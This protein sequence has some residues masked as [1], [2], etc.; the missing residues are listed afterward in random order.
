MSGYQP[1]GPAES[2]SNSR[3]RVPIYAAAAAFG[4]CALYSTQSLVREGDLTSVPMLP[5]ANLQT[6][7]I[8]TAP[9]ADPVEAI[10]AN[11]TIS[12]KIGQMIQV[13]LNTV[14]HGR[15]AHTALNK[16]MVRHYAK[17]GIGSYFNTAFD[18]SNANLEWNVKEWKHI[19]DEINRIYAEEHAVPMIY[20]IDMTHGAN[21]IRG[22]AMFP[23]PLAGASSF[24]L[25]L[26]YRMGEI[27]A[28]D[29]LAAGLQ[30]LFSPILGIAMHPK[31]ARNYETFGEDPYLVSRMGTSVIRGMQA[32]NRTAACMKHFIAYSNPINGNDRTDS[33]VPDFELANYYSPPF[34]A[35]VKEGNV[36][37]AMETYV[38]VNGEPVVASHKLLTD[39]LRHDM[40]FEGLLV[41]DDDEFH[42]L[43]SEHHAANNDK[44]AIY[45][46]FNHTSMDMNM[47]S[48]KPYKAHR[49]TEQLVAK[50]LLTEARLDE[51]VRRIL[52]LKYDLGVL[53]KN[54]TAY[55][56]PTAVGS[57]ED[58]RD[59][60]AMADEAIILLKNEPVDHSK[61]ALPIEDPNASVF[62]TG[63]LA[64]SKA[65]L[66]GGWSTVWQGTYKDSE[67]ANSITIR[68]GLSKSFSKLQFATGV[69]VEGK[70]VENR[71]EVLAKAAK[72]AYTIVVIG[73]HS[74]AE[75]TGDSDNLELPQGQLEYVRQLT[76]LN[77]T[78]VILVVVEG[79]PRL[80]NGV[81]RDAAAV[82]LSFLPCE[83]GGQAFA[84]IITGHVNPSAKLPITYPKD[85]G[86]V[87]L[88]Y[89]HRVNTECRDEFVD[90]DM[91]WTFGSGLSYTT[92][93]YGHVTLSQH[94]VP[95]TGSITVSVPVKNTGTRAGKESV[96]L[97]VS[98]K[99]RHNYVPETKLLK[100]FHKVSLKPNETTIVNFTLSTSDWS[101][102]E[103][104]IGKG[105]KTIS[106]PGAFHIQIKHDTDCN[107]N[108]HL[109]K[110]FHVEA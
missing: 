89:F 95:S 86:N 27:E 81:T 3:S 55:V 62:L 90:C 53:D 35:A 58:Q 52:R 67:I 105:F 30:W 45:Q 84:D 63:P 26:A 91:E 38:S 106:E 34:I 49:L 14:L 4:L 15:N 77:T 96:L 102:H 43:I 78:K 71:T 6:V 22:A 109:C 107:E 42:R 100:K 5:V 44:D 59:A 9:K 97:F 70:E 98:Q 54:Q 79:R 21:Y 85:S 88:P 29:S 56:P 40:G 69:D 74:Y 11:L 92:F 20:G 33:V 24:N 60:K 32:N 75:K 16:A 50:G 47:V 36:K 64:D 13:D 65:F 1:I 82:L 68:Q 61:K 80:L 8:P 108:I 72:S 17:L 2:A 51:S 110:T 41:S 23:Q 103:P 83:Q 10:L 25:D 104:Q 76:A 12:Q 101:Y 87:H 31:W 66:C 19:M 37:T 18:R 73:E 7:P 39:L 93:E 48:V 46:V 94:K 57:A 28:K 99:I